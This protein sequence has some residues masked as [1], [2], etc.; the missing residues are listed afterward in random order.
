MDNNPNLIDRAR[1]GDRHALNQLF[2]HWYRPVY[3]IAYRYFSDADLARE[4]CQQTFLHV[5][6]KLGQLREA[7][8]FR[9]WLYQIVVNLCHN[10]FRRT[11][12]RSRAY[13][14]Y[15]RMQPRLAVELPEER[16]EREEQAA[17]V[18]EALGRL[19]EEQRMVVIMKEYEGLTFREIAGVLGLSENTVKSRM[20]YGLK[21]LQ[22]FFLIQSPKNKIRYE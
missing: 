8:G 14:N 21:A 3:N 13:E 7:E 10:E 6:Q 19:P 11:Q 22:K 5:Q 12:S 17:R 16:Y 15:G 9:L 2:T 18:L 20:Y 4:L 1:K